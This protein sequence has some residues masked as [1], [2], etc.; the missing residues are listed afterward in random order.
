MSLFV[1]SAYS[2]S[3]YTGRNTAPDCVAVSSF[4]QP[5]STFPGRG[6]VMESTEA[7]FATVLQYSHV[8]F[9]LFFPFFCAKRY[10]DVGITVLLAELRSG[11]D[12]RETTFFGLVK[13]CTPE[14][15]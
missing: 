2:S 12:Q 5:L 10:L 11:V 4:F 7:A 9:S 6:P 14:R 8:F 3:L 1:F 15:P 13:K